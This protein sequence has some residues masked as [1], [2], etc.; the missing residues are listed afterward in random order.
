VDGVENFSH[1]LIQ[2]V[3]DVDPDY[4]KERRKLPCPSIA[5]ACDLKPVVSCPRSDF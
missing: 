4:R 1:T 5:I 3:R 2:L